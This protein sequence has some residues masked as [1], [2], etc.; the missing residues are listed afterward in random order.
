MEAAL[1]RVLCSQE[2]EAAEAL[3]RLKQNRTPDSVK[4]AMQ[5]LFPG[6]IG[7]S[8]GE[9]LAQADWSAIVSFAY[10]ESV[11]PIRSLVRRV[12]KKQL[13]FGT[14]S[15]KAFEELMESAN[16]AAVRVAAQDYYTCELARLFPKIVKRAER[17][18]VTP[19]V[20]AVP[21]YL[22]RYLNEAS[23]C[24]IYGQFLAALF[25]C[26]SALEEAVKDRLKATGHGAEVAR[27]ERREWLYAL[28]KLARDKK[29]LN[30]SAY[31]DADRIRGQA[32]DAIHGKYLPG[33]TECV[34]AYTDTRLVLQSL[35]A[36]G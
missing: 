30:K 5:V 35:Y 7:V 33:D 11:E 17:L 13:G 16:P 19:S 14:G 9:Q 22:Q 29:I 1:E 18:R 36:D 24:Y 34:K 10:H 32:K 8:A 25:L 31:R 26:R 27:I 28:L 23:R 15:E 2:P 6:P 12:V 20:Q 4:H 21:Q 3:F